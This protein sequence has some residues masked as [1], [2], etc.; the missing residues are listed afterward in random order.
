MMMLFRRSAGCL[1]LT[2]IGE[3][4]R[5]HASLHLLGC[6]DTE[7]LQHGWSN[8]K[9][10]GFERLQLYAF[11]DP[12]PDG[13]ERARY[14]IAVIIIVFGDDRRCS[15]V[16]SMGMWRLRITQRLDAVI[17]DHEE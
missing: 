4:L 12:R 1:G 14:L 15:R 13:Y 5:Q 16:V 6:L 3:D 11:L 17:R 10:A 2:S 8:I 9:H 7:E